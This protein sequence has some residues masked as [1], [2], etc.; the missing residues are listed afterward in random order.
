MEPV[1]LF[2]VV[3]VGCIECGESSAVLG[4]FDEEHL[5]LAVEVVVDHQKRQE[6]HWHGEHYFF[7]AELDG[8]LNLVHPVAYTEEEEEE[9]E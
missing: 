7:I 3:D 9:A 1:K 8:G 4:V 6:K 2:V 5:P